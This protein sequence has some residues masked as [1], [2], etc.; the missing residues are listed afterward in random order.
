MN[1][2]LV[3]LVISF[4]SSPL[5]LRIFFAKSKICHF[6]LPNAQIRS[7]KLKI[8]EICD[9]KKISYTK[10]LFQDV[11]SSFILFGIKPEEFFLYNFDK[12][13]YK[14]R[15]AFLSDAFRT[16][17]QKKYIGLD[18]FKKE[19]L[20]KYCFYRNNK[21]FF[22]RECILISKQSDFISFKE[23]MKLQKHAFIKVN[24]SSFGLNARKIEFIDDNQIEAEFKNMMEDSS[25]EWIVEELVEQDPRMAVWNNSSVNTIR[26]PS[27]L[28]D[29]RSKTRIFLP[30]IRTGRRGAVVDNAG[31][32]GIF[33]VIDE[34]TGRI[35]TDGADESFNRY[36][37]HPDTKLKF[38][39]WQVPDWDKLL[40]IA[41]KAHL[42]MKHHKYIAYDFALTPKGWILIEGNWGQYLC[43]QTSTQEGV[44]N[45]YLELL[46]N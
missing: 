3:N 8:N 31:A 6:I 2:F 41:L 42:R 11:I 21:E 24:N 1:R 44:K 39:G 38:K 26:I 23:F 29:K 35:I 43:Q 7:L 32:G 28:L 46:K 34:K 17:L 16:Q 45:K 27:F 40:N 33:A 19:L 15:D 37:F 36:E 12:L 4:W 18:L 20:D 25:I 13:S 30:F 14:E 9:R 10:S 22:K 5:K